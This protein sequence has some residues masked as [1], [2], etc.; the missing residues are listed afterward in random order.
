MKREK[1][2]VIKLWD[3][4]L[5]IGNKNNLRLE[6]LIHIFGANSIAVIKPVFG[7]YMRI[8]MISIE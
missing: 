4:K 5:M 8:G 2:K 7:K 3:N 1:T 6:E